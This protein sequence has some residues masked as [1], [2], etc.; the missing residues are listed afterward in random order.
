[1]SQQK[2]MSDE[3]FI[4]ATEAIAKYTEETGLSRNRIASLVNEIEIC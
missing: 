2:K 4:V 3:M 1:M